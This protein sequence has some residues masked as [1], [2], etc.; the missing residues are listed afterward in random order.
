MKKK[1]LIGIVSIL[2]VIQFVRIDKVNPPLSPDKDFVNLMKPPTE[3][4]G[5]IKG[6]C[7]DC[8]SNE[9]KYPW[10]TNV[11]PL[12]WWLKQHINDGR[13]K[14]NFS[15]WGT[16]SK[17]D[18]AELLEECYEELQEDEM[19]LQS[20]RFAH[21]EARFNPAQKDLLLQWLA[22]KGAKHHGDDD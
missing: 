21:A 6:A 17:K 11:A 14:M 9:T 3:V 22:S 15:T 4:A 8:H 18:L 10:Y 13:K 12:S 19:P 1:I 5:L 20:Y 7:Y 2:V 16:M